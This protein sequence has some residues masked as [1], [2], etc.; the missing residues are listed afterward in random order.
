MRI[1]GGRLSGRR[2]DGP[3]GSGTRPTSERVREAVCSALASRN[4]FDGAEVLDLFAGT[5]ALAFEALSRGA[6]RAWLVDRDRRVTRALRE[7]AAKLALETEATVV[8][9]DL[10]GAADRIVRALEHHTGG[11]ASLVFA[12][13]PYADAG[14][15]GVLFR[16]LLD[17]RVTRPDALFVAE[18]ASKTPPDFGPGLATQASYRYGDTAIAF[19]TR[20]EGTSP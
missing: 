15:L 5:G 2:F 17:G 19:L 4:A 6:T 12:D 7:N 16:A 8:E 13:P 9:L 3:P 18:F 14:K 11:K 20:D 1:V 10:L